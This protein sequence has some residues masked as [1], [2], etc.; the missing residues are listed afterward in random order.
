MVVVHRAY[1]FRFV[2]CTL[3]HEPAQVHITGVGQTKINLPGLDGVAEIVYSIGIKRSDMRRLPGRW[4]SGR[5]GRRCL[6]TSQTFPVRCQVTVN[7]R[8]A[9]MAWARSTLAG[10]AAGVSVNS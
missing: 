3:D 8:E 2:I 1:G 4:R 7:P 9:N 6:G 5:N 10:S